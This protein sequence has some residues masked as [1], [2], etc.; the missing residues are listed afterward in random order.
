MTDLDNVLKSRDIT[1]PALY[2]Q[3]YG[4]PSGDVEL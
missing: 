3:G 4:L 1:L 2:S